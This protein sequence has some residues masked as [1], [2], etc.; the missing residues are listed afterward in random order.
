MWKGPRVSETKPCE[1]AWDW[2][3]PS[4]WQAGHVVC[5]PLAAW[6]GADVTT[7]LNLCTQPA[8]MGL[9]AVSSSPPWLVGEPSETAQPST[10][11]P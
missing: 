8:N 10:C 9:A 3:G 6:P 7:I 2:A 11:G 5:G 1:Q 4:L